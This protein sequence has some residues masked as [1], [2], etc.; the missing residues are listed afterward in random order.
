MKNIRVYSL[1]KLI[2]L[3]QLNDLPDDVT[4]HTFEKL[5]EEHGAFMDTAAIMQHLDLVISSD[6]SIAHLAGGLGVPTFLM[7]P[8]TAEWRWLIDRHD[9]PW[10]PTMKLFRQK[11]AGEWSPMMKKILYEL[12]NLIN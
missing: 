1:Q 3:G 2:G 5:D 11:K 6:T 4:L 9:S 8:Y 10:Y 12:Q 7:L